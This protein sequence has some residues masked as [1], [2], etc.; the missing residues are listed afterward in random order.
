MT[1]LHKV[2]EKLRRLHKVFGK[3]SATAWWLTIP[4]FLIHLVYCC[5]NQNWDTRGYNLIIDSVAFL[6]TEA[7]IWWVAR[8]VLF[9]LFGCYI[10]KHKLGKLFILSLVG[11][12]GVYLHVFLIGTQS[13]TPVVLKYWWFI[14]VIWIIATASYVY[15]QKYMR[16]VLLFIFIAGM[17]VV[18]IIYSGPY[19]VSGEYWIFEL[20]FLLQDI[21]R[22]IAVFFFGLWLL[23]ME[24]KAMSGVI[25]D[26]DEDIYEEDDP[27]QED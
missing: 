18:P 13:S 26:N 11:L 24:S 23:T 19:T 7:I 4:L 17:S 22:V 15:F 12:A 16:F 21:F 14:F 9:A 2:D 6:K 25:E 5:M 20:S 8:I 27:S 10:L 3:I 1:F